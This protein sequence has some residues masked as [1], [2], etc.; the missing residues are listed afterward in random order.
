MSLFQRIKFFFAKWT[1][2]EITSHENKSNQEHV[3][4]EEEL[5]DQTLED[6]FPCSD[7]PG[8]FSK[9]SEDRLNH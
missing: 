2:A 9:S 8:H 3:M 6:S 4:T 1:C 7:P 5:L